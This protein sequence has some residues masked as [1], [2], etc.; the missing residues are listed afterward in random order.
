MTTG[1]EDKVIYC[2]GDSIDV[3]SSYVTR[4]AGHRNYQALEIVRNAGYNAR[5]ASWA[6]SGN[7]MNQFVGY[8]KQG[9]GRIPHAD[10]ILVQH[11]AN[12]IGQ[13]ITNSKFTE[14]LNYLKLWR[15][16]NFKGSKLVVVKVAPSSEGVAGGHDRNLIQEGYNLQIDNFVAAN[17]GNEIYTIDVYSNVNKDGTLHADGVHL[18]QAGHDIMGPLLGNGLKSILGI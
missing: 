10:V 5:I 18:N 17:Q 14:N 2:L 4:T 3:L 12:D 6:M 16:V 7:S 1:K 11:G 15:D 9:N 13:N 8:M